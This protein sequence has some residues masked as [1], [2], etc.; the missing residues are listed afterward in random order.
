MR[1]I[2]KMIKSVLNEV[3]GSEKIVYNGTEIDFSGDWPVRSFRELI[4]DDSGIDID[5]YETKDKLL[6]IIQEKSIELPE[7]LDVKKI[8]R[9]NLIDALYKK[10]SRPAI[11]NPTF[12]VKHPVEIS[13]L[14]RCNDENKKVADRFQ[15][16]VNGWEVVNAYSEL[17]DPIDQKER[18][19]QQAQ[20]REGGDLEAMEF[21]EDFIECMEYGMPPMSGL[22][23]GIDRF[24]ALITDSSSL[25][26]VVLFPLMRSK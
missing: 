16:V 4:R 23:M 8:S 9:G 12:L 17:V 11:I 1:F 21:D 2:E 14:A 26:D 25:R 20:A 13:P 7:K 19:I 15:L 10:V 5:Q 24:I 3:I 6:R 18:F 22:G